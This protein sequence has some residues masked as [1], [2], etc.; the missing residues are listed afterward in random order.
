FIATWCNHILVWI[1]IWVYQAFILSGFL[2]ASHE[3]A[4]NTFTNHK[5]WN[6]IIGNFWSSTVLFNFSLYKYYHLNHHKL[7]HV[8]GDTEPYGSFR[9]ITDYFLTIP[10]TGFFRSEER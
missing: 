9:N 5:F 1:A 2:G 4:H 7:T 10:M 6:R 3:C 8:D